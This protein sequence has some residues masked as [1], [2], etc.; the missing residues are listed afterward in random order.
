MS[1]IDTFNYGWVDIEATIPENTS[2]TGS[3]ID[4][5]DNVVPGYDNVTFPF[6]LAGVDSEEYELVRIKVLMDTSDEEVS[7]KLTKIS[8]GG[9]R[10]LAASSADY[11]GWSFSPSIEV[12]DELLNATTIAGTITSDYIH[13]SRP[14]KS[15]T[16]SGNFSSG[17]MVTAY[18]FT[19]ATLGQTS[20]G[21]IPFAIPQT[22]FSLSAFII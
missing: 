8:I 22:G 17:L 9:K 12:V 5:S 4:I 11:N 21:S 14:I 16:L 7:P 3:L 2:I 15:V 1:N 6:S 10:Y 18:S 13:S 20:Q 19:G